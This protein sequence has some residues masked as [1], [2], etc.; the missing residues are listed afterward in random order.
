MPQLDAVGADNDQACDGIAA[1][2]SVD[3]FESV[4]RP[5]RSDNRTRSADH[6]APAKKRTP[7]TA[8]SMCPETSATITST[9]PRALAAPATRRNALFAAAE[10]GWSGFA[11]T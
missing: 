10:I 1:M 4:A 11:T 6:A 9:T 2:L 7:A 3:Q 5:M 8:N